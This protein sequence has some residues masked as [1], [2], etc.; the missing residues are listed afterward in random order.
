MADIAKSTEFADDRFLTFKSEGHLYALPARSVSE[1]ARMPPVARVPQAPPSLMG[2]VN[3][4][5]AVLPVAS[6]RAL[7]GRADVATT[8]TSR[9]IVLE[10]ASPVALAVD[11]VASLVRIA[12]EKV[13]TAEADIASE[14]GE[15]LRGVFETNSHVTKILDI[16]ELL[17]RGFA[18]TGLKRLSLASTDGAM[19]AVQ[20]AAVEMIRQRLVTFQVAGQ[21]Y[22]LPLEVIREIVTAP[23]NLTFVPGSDDAVRGVM[24]YR[25]GLL[26]LLSLRRLLGLPPAVLSREKV[27]IV[28]IGDVLIGFVADRAR[29]VL[30]VDPGRVEPAP[31]IL[32]ARAGGEAQI[33]EIYRAGHGRL[34]S[35][36]APE[37]LL[38]EDVMQKL[39]Q[40]DA[41]MK[42]KTDVIRDESHAKELRFLVF[43]LDDNEFALP[44]DAVEEVARVPD[45]ITRLPKTPKFLE[46]VVNL[47]G[48]VLPVVDQRR[49]FEMTAATVS[50]H[51]RLV[52][53]RTE[54]HRAGLIVDSVSEVLRCS[55]D[56][57]QPSPDLTGDALGIVHSVIN[58]ESHGRIILLLDPSELL[59]RTE[60]GL[61]DSF[62]KETRSKESR[63][64][65]P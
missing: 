38:R 31:A 53:V 55:P 4:R 50:V 16:P 22:A 28:A 14:A 48:E 63:Q 35:I 27:L 2:L 8:N 59:T 3:L 47:R 7:L 57:I 36:L 32:A 62:S 29:A 1:V 51:R 13:K 20:H 52:V 30:S 9:L 19:K 37:R 56:S 46:G 25:D 61:L 49:R 40:G 54:Q 33:K 17:R 6:V 41:T 64:T 43:R 23:E 58:L 65:K 34:V 21:D 60:R 18:Q 39:M 26:P 45:Q 11:E 42:A 5:G 10:G 44:I 12:P 24:A 15:H